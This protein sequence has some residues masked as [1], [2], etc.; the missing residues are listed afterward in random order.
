MKQLVFWNMTWIVNVFLL[1]IK[2]VIKVQFENCNYSDSKMLS[3]KFSVLS[4]W[5]VIGCCCGI[6]I[7]CGLH[8]HKQ[9][10]WLSKLIYWRR[11]AIILSKTINL[12]SLLSSLLCAWNPEA[13]RQIS[14]KNASNPPR[15][16][17]RNSLLLFWKMC[18]SHLFAIR[19]YL[20]F[21]MVHM[22]PCE[23]LNVCWL[24]LMNFKFKSPAFV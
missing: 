6:F 5:L 7:D 3:I 14:K 9:I 16:C 13:F 2:I 11:L 15:V 10:S 24:Y 12:P 4:L 21:D 23:Q 22:R 1:L 8:R 20:L 19:G 17:D 18:S